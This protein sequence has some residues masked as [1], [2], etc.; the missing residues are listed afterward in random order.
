KIRW[1]SDLTEDK[2]KKLERKE[3]HDYWRVLAPDIEKTMRFFLEICPDGVYRAPPAMQPTDDDKKH[4]DLLTDEVWEKLQAEV[5]EFLST[6][7]VG[8][9]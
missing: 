3:G 5:D 4:L 8:E 9:E 2:L 1:W 6:I 7:K